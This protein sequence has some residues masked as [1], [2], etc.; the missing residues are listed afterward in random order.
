MTQPFLGQ[1]TITA[2]NFPA[3]NWALC[4]GQLVP[5]VQNT[6]LFSLLGTMYGGDGRQTF[7]LPDLRGRA[8][9]HVSPDL[10]QGAGGGA[11]SVAL[12]AGQMPAHTHT[13]NAS[14]DLA[15]TGVP[16]NAAPA[17]RPRGGPLLYRAPGGAVAAMHPAAVQTAGGGQAHS[18]MQPYAV[19]SYMIAL[20]GIFPSRN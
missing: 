14:A 3:R 16:S 15:N 5:I 13:L 20:Q 10:P 12:T 2:F 8:P 17:A 18:N 11:E 1:V 6:A 7:A 4:D 19:V 9:V